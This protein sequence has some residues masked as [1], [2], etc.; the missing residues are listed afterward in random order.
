M[1]SMAMMKMWPPSSTGI[2]IRFSRPRFRLIDAISASSAIQPVLRRLA[3]QL[4][5]ADRAHQ[6][7]R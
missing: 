3:G 2:G 7:L 5:D 6:L 4:R 1:V